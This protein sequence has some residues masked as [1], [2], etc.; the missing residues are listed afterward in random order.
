MHLTED[1]IIGILMEFATDC[2]S[3]SSFAVETSSFA[4]VAHT[5]LTEDALIE[6]EGRNGCQKCMT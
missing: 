3:P 4:K 5:I 1:E 2:I 6:L